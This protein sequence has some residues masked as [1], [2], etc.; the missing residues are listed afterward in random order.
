MWNNLVFEKPV[1]LLLSHG[2]WL[3]AD[4]MWLFVFGYFA[5]YKMFPS[6]QALWRMVFGLTVFLV[7]Y[8]VVLSGLQYQVWNKAAPSK[9]FLPP[10]TPISYFLTYAGYHFFYRHAITVVASFILG[11]MFWFANRD[12]DRRFMEPYE[13]PLLVL[14]GLMAGWPNFFIYLALGLLMSLGWGIAARFF[15]GASRVSLAL[16]FFLA[17]GIVLAVGD[18]LAPLLF[19]DRIRI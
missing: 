11:A 17:A 16:P 12:Y 4:A 1:E 14:G 13:I 7:L 15:F 8:G 6:A 5:R 2:S 18:V 10:Y 9:Y 3:V 19:L